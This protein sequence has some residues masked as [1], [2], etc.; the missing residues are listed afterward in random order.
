MKLP[1][2]KFLCVT[3]AI[4]KICEGLTQ[5]GELKV[6][7]TKEINV[8]ASITNAQNPK[9]EIL[10]DKDMSRFIFNGELNG[11]EKTTGIIEFNGID[12]LIRKSTL[13]LNPNGS[14]HHTTLYCT[15]N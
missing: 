7:L 15:S 6:I 14:V 5:D 3:P 1:N 2:I 8:Y 11:F 13:T 10:E 12:Y 4:F 9:G